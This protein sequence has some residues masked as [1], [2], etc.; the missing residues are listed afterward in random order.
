MRADILVRV[1]AAETVSHDSV[2]IKNVGQLYSRCAWLAVVSW[3]CSLRLMACITIAR[4]EIGTT[5]VSV[6]FQEGRTY[7]IEIVTDAAALVEKLK[8]CRGSR[9]RQPHAG[10]AELL[11]D[12]DENF[13]SE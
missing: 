2:R 11:Q 5:R 12:F 6:L 1:P 9:H 3:H 10:T 13:A 8:A 7:D 4:T